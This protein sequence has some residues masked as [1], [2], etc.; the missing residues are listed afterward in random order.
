MSEERILQA[1]N[2]LGNN[3]NDFK[4]E[5]KANFG[6]VNERIDSTNAEVKSITTRLDKF[7]DETRTNFVSMSQMFRHTNERITAVDKKVTE[8]DKKMEKRFQENNRDIG[9]ALNS[10][11]ESIDRNYVKKDV[12]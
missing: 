5:T 2:E 12:S 8:L 4:E 7:E 10:A 9:V 1:I 11:F 3:L 6:L